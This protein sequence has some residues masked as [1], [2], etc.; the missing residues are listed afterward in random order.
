MH[1]RQGIKV[2]NLRHYKECNMLAMSFRCANGWKEIKGF[3][4]CA[5]VLLPIYE[6]CLTLKLF[7][8]LLFSWCKPCLWPTIVHNLTITVF[9]V[10][11]TVLQIAQSNH[12]MLYTLPI[13]GNVPKKKIEKKHRNEIGFVVLSQWNNFYIISL[14]LLIIKKIVG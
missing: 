6:S 8:S 14:L 12:L 4:T 7:T 9:H 2:L 13:S 3:Y 5:Y 1:V 11:H 10:M